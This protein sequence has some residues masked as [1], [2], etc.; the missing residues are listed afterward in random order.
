M[1]NKSDTPLS[2]IDCSRASET[3]GEP[4][5]GAD[6]PVNAFDFET[7]DGEPVMLAYCYDGEEPGLVT[8]TS[9]EGA[10]MIGTNTL[11]K[12]LTASKN[13]NSLNVWYNLNFDA[14]VL[15]KGLSRQQVNEIQVSGTTQVTSASGVDW[16]VTYIPKKVLKFRDENNH[17]IAHYDISQFADPYG[18]PLNSAA[19][20]WIGTGKLDDVDMKEISQNSSLGADG[21]VCGDFD[22]RWQEISEYAERD[23]EITRDMAKEIVRVAETETEP[24]I[25]MGQPFSTGYGAAE[26]IRAHYEYKPKFNRKAVQK[27]AWDAYAGGRFEVFERGNVGAVA[28]PDINSAYPAIMSELADPGC[29]HWKPISE[30]ADADALYGD[31]VEYSFVHARVTTDADRRIQPFAVK[32]QSEGGRVEYPA[33]DDAEITAIGPIFKFALENDY[34]EEYEILG[35]YV[36]KEIDDVEVKY[37]FENLKEIYKRRKR[38]ETEGKDK[39]ATL[40]KIVMNS[41]YGKTCQTTYKYRSLEEWT[42]DPEDEDA[43][44]N[45]PT[46]DELADYA[47][48]NDGITSDDDEL[49]RAWEDF[50][51]IPDKNG[52]KKLYV[53]SQEAGGLFNPI[54]ASYITGMTRLELHKQVVNYGLEQDTYMFATD[55]IMIDRDAFQA[56][57]FVA[58]LQGDLLGEWDFDYAGGDA[59][60]LG[61]GIYEVWENGPQTDAEPMKTKTR[62]FKEWKET[63]LYGEMR[64]ADGPLPVVSVRPIT[65]G[66]ALHKGEALHDVAMFKRTERGIKPDMDG[67]RNWPSEATWESL[68]GDVE[69]GDPKVYDGSN[70]R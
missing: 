22:D 35:G 24:A 14:Q 38:L 20:E 60:I 18:A 63:S 55:C 5:W 69:T 62:G 7:V 46:M 68:T 56:S 41:L 8:N 64:D 51:V 13:R 2:E 32:N 27:Y 65:I 70:W 58:D 67:K 66:D 33:L 21:Y 31:D 44:E 10:R 61:S 3:L 34:I 40:L 37:P 50:D 54:V 48:K 36:G 12:Y 1:G 52:E 17:T 28:G 26:W 25:P 39:Q 49:L 59:Y 45:V 47:R 9:P 15:L 19:Q 43:D 23:A 53:R 16:T 57:N 30:G 42:R 6:K 29:L 11:W 4:T